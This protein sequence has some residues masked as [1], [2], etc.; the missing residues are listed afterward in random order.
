MV[1]WNVTAETI[2]RSQVADLISVYAMRQGYS[3][4]M[5]Y[6]SVPQV[7]VQT[8]LLTLTSEQMQSIGG[9]S[10]L[11]KNMRIQVVV[12]EYVQEDLVQAIATEWNAGTVPWALVRHFPMLSN[13]T[14]PAWFYFPSIQNDFQFEYRGADWGACSASCGPGVKTRAPVECFMPLLNRTVPVMECDAYLAL[15]PPELE[16]NNYT[17]STRCQLKD[18][19]G[20]AA[21]VLACIIAG[22]VL[23]L[24]AVLIGI[25]CRHKREQSGGA[26]NVPTLKSANAGNDVQMTAVGYDT[27]NAAQQ[28]VSA[29]LS[30]MALK[31]S[32]QNYQNYQAGETYSGYVPSSYGG[33]SK[34]GGFAGQNAF[35]NYAPASSVAPR[36]TMNPS[37]A[38]SSGPPV[39][40]WSNQSRQQLRD[41]L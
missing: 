35:S 22:G 6:V 16:P 27:G 29:G 8:S 28:S 21:W 32:S 15:R 34:A 13:R 11:D 24:L 30:A 33:A 36:L 14:A 7:V 17:E 2:L 12:P 39:S 4:S 41:L 3:G 37:A 18:D 19:C 31:A 1:R 26:A 23:L 5:Q 40:P 20:L 38:A 10:S 25:S 9:M